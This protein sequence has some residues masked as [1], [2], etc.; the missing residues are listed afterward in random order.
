MSRTDAKL[1]DQVQ[2]VLSAPRPWS[3]TQVGESVLRGRAAPYDGQLPEHL[4]HEL[5]DAMHAYLPGVGVGL[6]APQIGI[7]L[8]LAVISDPADVAPEVAT[9]R[10]RQPQPGLDLV[11][12]VVT[13]L[14]TERRAFYEG[15]LS[16]TGLTAVVSRYRRVQLSA[17]DRT[18][19]AYDLELSGWPARI[20]QHETDH[21]NGVLYLDRAELR[22]LSTIAAYEQHWAQS[23]PAAASVALD[24]SI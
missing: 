5:L 19:R 15:C 2:A 14:G 21:L 17:Q 9:A 8:A 24:F 1:V 16:V 22:S 12:P 7:P 18:G 20:A 3:I 6:A 13:P 23:T 4:L 11:N 10:E